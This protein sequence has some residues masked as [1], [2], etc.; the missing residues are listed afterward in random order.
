MYIKGIINLKGHVPTALLCFSNTQ[1]TFPSVCIMTG[2]WI[3]GNVLF[4]RLEVHSI[5]LVL[6]VGR[7][8]LS[9]TFQSSLFGEAGL[10]HHQSHQTVITVARRGHWVVSPREALT[11]GR[12]VHKHMTCKGG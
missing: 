5:F 9:V 10:P 2:P 4:S 6:F 12:E 11:V 3:Q 7:N 1:G 8:R